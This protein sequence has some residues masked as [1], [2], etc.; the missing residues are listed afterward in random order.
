[1]GGIPESG[2]LCYSSQTCNRR[3]F[4]SHLRDRYNT[5]VIGQNPF[6]NF[7]TA[8]AWAETGAAGQPLTEVVNPLMTSPYCFRNETRFFSD[9]DNLSVEGRDILSSDCRDNPTF[10]N[11]SHVLV[12][13]CSS[14]L[15]LGSDERQD[16]RCDCWDQDCFRYNPTSEDLQFTFRGQT[17]FRSVLQ[18]LDRL[19]N[20]KTASEIV[21]VGSSAGGVG[22][23]NS[24]KWVRGTFQNVSLKVITDSSWF[25]DFRGSIEQ[26]FGSVSGGGSSAAPNSFRDLLQIV[27]SSSKACTDT[28]RGYPCCL[29][30]ECLLTKKNRETGESYFPQGVSVF[31]LTSIYDVFLLANALSGLVPVSDDFSVAGLALQFTI[32]V[33]EYGGAMND[34]LIDTA[35]TASLLDIHFSY[36]AT[37]CF[38]HIYL[39]TSTLRSENGLIGADEIQLD[40]TFAMFEHRIESGVWGREIL[41]Y[42]NGKGHTIRSAIDLWYNHSEESLV[43]RDVCSGP[44]CSN[45]CPE[46]IAL[47]RK[48]EAENWSPGVE[49]AI[50][51][52]VLLI[53]VICLIMKM[54]CCVWLGLLHHKQRLFLAQTLSPNDEEMPAVPR[55]RREFPNCI[56]ANAIS[57]ACLDLHY[58][59]TVRRNAQKKSEKKEAKIL[60]A[61]L[62]GL[63]DNGDLTDTIDTEGQCVD[64]EYEEETS[65]KKIAKTKKIL[66]GISAYFNPGELIAIMGPSGCGKTTF[67]DILTGRRK[68]GTTM[69]NIFV[70]GCQV[71]N[72][73]NW[74]ISNTGYVLQLAAPYYKELTVRENLTLAAWVKLHISSKEKF[75]RVEQVMEVTGLMDLADTV[76]G[77][78]TGPGLSGGQKRRLVVALQLLKLPSVIFLDEPTS[79]LDS[80]SSTE[81]LTHLNSLAASNRTVVLTIHQPRLEIF[82]MFH[83]IVVLTDGKVAY[84]GVPENA[85]EVFVDALQS[86]FLSQ[87]VKI[88]LLEDHN[89]ADIIMDMLGDRKMRKI[90]NSYYEDSGEPKLVR[91]AV[92]EARRKEQMF[93]AEN[94]EIDGPNTLAAKFKTLRVIVQGSRHAG[95][96]HNY[97]VVRLAALEARA[98]KRANL[99]TI[100]YLPIIFFGYGF[101]LGTVYFQT[102]EPFLIMS[103]FCVYSVASALFMFPAMYTFFTQA[104]ELYRFEHADGAGR[105]TDLVI[106]PFVRFISMAFFPVIICAGVL[107]VLAVD[108]A[109]WNGIE[110]LQLALVNLALNQTWTSLL[111]W[112]ILIFPVK[113]FRISPVLSALA[114][115]TSG[116]FIPINKIPLWYRW[117]SFINPNYYGF[118]ASAVILLSDFESDCERDGGSE[119]ECYTASGDYILEVFGFD[120]VNPYQNIAIL[121]GMTVFFLLLLD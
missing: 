118:S 62:S 69:G 49:I 10:C 35:D 89:P 121:L 98:M 60:P 80:A 55:L 97:S 115:F 86:A 109:R 106:Q 107:Y 111:I 72:N 23:L 56:D 95:R 18:T 15:W 42:Y 110:F 26:E 113:A 25:I 45:T 108:R 16:Q 8:V 73:R 36:F 90:V 34:S 17:I 76:V 4:Q 77:G 54:Y 67:L 51:A 57:V 88:P 75:Q 19:Y 104:M 53:G 12:P 71:E 114:G 27:G 81:L 29:S 116:F 40:H 100:L 63:Q 61:A 21:L 91:K 5:D 47:S 58:C 11:H 41:G 102:S 83:R 85:Y 28:R 3:Y 32:T 84:H 2:S 70:N 99:M 39:S 30:P 79:G 112:L 120:N 50:A 48:E 64:K 65:Q 82:H 117:M 92:D 13:Y 43:F 20:L 31:S 14:D 46:K 44:H 101:L 1:M 33:G 94:I 22:V 68:T 52:V 93:N 9:S 119:L 38:Q 103:G 66:T 7:D 6:G 78:A 87:G 24:A 105:A 37:Q 74:Y 96:T 59:V